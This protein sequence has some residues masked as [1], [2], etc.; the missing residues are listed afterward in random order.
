MASNSP[1]GPSLPHSSSRAQWCPQNLRLTYNS[2]AKTQKTPHRSTRTCRTSRD[3]TLPPYALPLPE[4]MSRPRQHHLSGTPPASRA[5]STVL[6]T[7]SFRRG[8]CRRPLTPLKHSE[9][10]PVAD[11]TGPSHGQTT[12]IIRRKKSWRTRGLIWKDNIRLIRNRLVFY[13]I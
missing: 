6:D 7:R 9:V 1:A 12:L 3:W 4:M 5:S 13:V 11:H 2:P 8:P 10:P